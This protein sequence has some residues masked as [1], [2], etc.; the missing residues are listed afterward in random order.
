M[1]KVLALINPE[2]GKCTK[3]LSLLFELHRQG[4]KVERF[5]LVLENT[6]HAQKWVL[7]LSMPLSKEE[8][9]KIK[10]RYRKKVLSEWE[11]LGGPKVDVVVEVNEAHKTVEKLDLSEVELLVLG[12]L[13]SKSLCKL[14]ET[15]DK[16]A[17]VIKN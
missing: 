12:C 2:N 11:A 16:P 6:Y 8:V 14:I 1:K 4:W 5:V 10:E 3:T 13:E 15:L 7:S 9:E 17:L